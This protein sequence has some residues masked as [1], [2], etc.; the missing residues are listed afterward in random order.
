ME[1]DLP[2]SLLPCPQNAPGG[3]DIKHTLLTEDVDVVDRE[4]A[5]LAV[6]LQGGDLFTYDLLCSYFCRAASRGRDKLVSQ[7][8]HARNRST[9]E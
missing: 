9:S 4:A 2:P 8:S 7:G 6:L 5:L 1:V 3:I